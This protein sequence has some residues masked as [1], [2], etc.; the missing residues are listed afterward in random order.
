M[1]AIEDINGGNHWTLTFGSSVNPT[2]YANNSLPENA[3]RDIHLLLL[4][5]R[6]STTLIVLLLKKPPFFRPR[7]DV[8]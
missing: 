6:V 3:I 1:S 5:L 7:G 2:N 4:S 8:E